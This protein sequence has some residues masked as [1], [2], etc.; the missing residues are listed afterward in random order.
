MFLQVRV[1]SRLKYEAIEILE[2]LGVG[3]PAAIRMFLKWKAKYVDYSEFTEALKLVPR[4]MLTRYDDVLD[5]LAHKYN[6]ERIE[7]GPH[8]FW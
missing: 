2:H 8:A 5:Y 4:G 6:A 7:I 3:M 1:D